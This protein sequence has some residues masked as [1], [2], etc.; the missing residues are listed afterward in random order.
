MA[1]NQRPSG[2][3]WARRQRRSRIR[4]NRCWSVSSAQD[5]WRRR[6]ARTRLNS[7]VARSLRSMTSSR[8]SGAS[9]YCHRCNYPK[10]CTVSSRR[11]PPIVVPV[12]AGAADRTG[13]VQTISAPADTACAARRRRARFDGGAPHTTQLY[14]ATN[15]P[16]RRPRLGTCGDDEAQVC[17]LSMPGTPRVTRLARCVSP[18]GWRDGG[19][20][21]PSRQG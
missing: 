5:G 11:R 16:A 1:I 4:S 13:G 3:A 12:G 7:L 21:G 9:T 17:R 2:G 18:G 8:R 19:G 20:D 14:A 6:R 10:R 15:R